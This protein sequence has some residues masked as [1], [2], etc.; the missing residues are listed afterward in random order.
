MDGARIE[1]NVFFKRGRK[2]VDAAVYDEIR[3]A[4]TRQDLEE[5]EDILSLLLQARH[6]DG[7]AMTD[8]ELRD[9]LMTL[10]LAGHETTATSLAWAMERLRGPPGGDGPPDTRGQG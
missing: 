2:K 4:R 10:L 7:S 9:E 1:R 6:E 5:R 3:H 8:E